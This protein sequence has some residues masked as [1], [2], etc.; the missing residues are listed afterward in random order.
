GKMVKLERPLKVK[1]QISFDEQEARRLQ[2]IFDEDAR[3][4]EEEAKRQKKYFAAK[5][6]KEH[7]SKPPTK[8]QKRK[9]MS[10]YLKNMVGWKLNQL[11]N[12]NIDSE[13]LEG[14]SKRA[15]SEQEQEA[16]KKQKIKDDK[17]TAKLQMLVEI[18]PDEEKVA[19]D[20]IPL[21]IKPPVIVDYKIHKEENSSYYKITRADGNLYV[22][23]KK[24]PLTLATITELLNKKLQGRIVGIQ[25]LLDA[26]EVAAAEAHD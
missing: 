7:R 17:E 2:A 14:S 21:A 18:I 20:A 25:R 4:A 10:T 13:M 1:D 9:T 5:R 16:K 12:K 26:V 24:Y 8:A 19:V 3:V 6:A 11:K 23:E 15:G 22:V